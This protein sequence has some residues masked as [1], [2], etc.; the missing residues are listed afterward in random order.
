[1]FYR[2]MRTPTTPE[3][4]QRKVTKKIGKSAE[5]HAKEEFNA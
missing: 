1:M 5:K 4:Y 2:P 3:R